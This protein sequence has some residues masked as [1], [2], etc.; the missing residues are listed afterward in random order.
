MA[1]RTQA[2]EEDCGQ[3]AFRFWVRLRRAQWQGKCLAL[4]DVPPVPPAPH[5]ARGM[6]L[7]GG[8]RTRTWYVSLFFVVF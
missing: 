8:P 3:T 6:V 2:L 7:L 5:G 4:R 1:E